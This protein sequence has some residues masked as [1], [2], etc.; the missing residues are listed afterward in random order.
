MAIIPAII[1][2]KDSKGNLIEGLRDNGGISLYEFQLGAD[3]CGGREEQQLQSAIKLSSVKI[4]KQIDRVTPR[5]YSIGYNNERINQIVI[6]LYRIN[7]GFEEE[8][9]NYILED[10][11]IVSIRNFISFNYMGFED[12]RRMEEVNLTIKHFSCVYLSEN[13]MFTTSSNETT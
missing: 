11:R 7:K 12:V 8:Y 6:K 3:F 9:L 5:L 13:S 2:I 4:V 1:M 10:C